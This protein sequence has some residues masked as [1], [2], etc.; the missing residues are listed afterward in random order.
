MSGRGV[1]IK[2]GPDSARSRLSKERGGSRAGKDRS[3]KE[4]PE[5]KQVVMPRD[6]KKSMRPS[7]EEAKWQV[8][9][10][11]APPRPLSEL[12]LNAAKKLFFQLDTDGSG[13]IDQEELGTMMRQ[14][15]QNPTEAELHDLIKSVDDE[16]DGDGKIQLREF[17]VLYTRGLDTRDL[18]G[19]NDVNNIFAAMGGDVRDKGSSVEQMHVKATL[20]DQFGLEIDFAQLGYSKAE[21]SKDD[22]EDL[23]LAP[24]GVGKR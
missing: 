14:L 15:G 1:S 22:F 20:L 8:E 3:S 21:L 13:S 11:W 17:L 7:K 2:A 5:R 24:T 4:S 19:M 18:P 23:L 16:G 6:R 12:E 9:Q 10:K